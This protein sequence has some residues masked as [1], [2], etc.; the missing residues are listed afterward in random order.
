MNRRQFLAATAA[1]TGAIPLLAQNYSDYSRDPRPDVAEG[2]LT[3]GSSPGPV[4]TGS[5]V[6]SG[7]AGD[8][9]TILQPVQRAVT[10]YL[11]YAVEDGAYE[12]VDAEQSGMLPFVEHVLKFRLPPLPAGKNVRYR[13]AARSVGWVKV[14]QFYHGELRA[15]EWQTSREHTFRTLD[16]QSEKTTFA[17][18]NDTHENP[19]TLKTLHALTAELRPDLLLWNG[20]QSNDVH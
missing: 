12:R 11:E 17:V 10:G 1:S 18:W 2:M 6:I 14:K 16:P 20:D 7:P 8:S 15:G 9:I 4:F 19:E 5:P 3:A 13:C